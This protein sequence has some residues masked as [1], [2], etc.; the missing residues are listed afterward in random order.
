M[1]EGKLFQNNELN[2]RADNAKSY[3]GTISIIKEYETSMQRQ[4]ILKYTDS[5]IQT[6]GV[7]LKDSKVVMAK[8]VGISRST[9]NFKM[10][11]IRF[12]D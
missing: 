10:N 12:L 5:P 7:Y 6:K 3:Q 2:Y 4:N 1:A 9:I 11:L 8:D